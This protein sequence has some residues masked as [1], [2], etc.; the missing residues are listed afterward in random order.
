MPRRVVLIPCTEDRENQL[1]VLLPALKAREPPTTEFY[2]CQPSTLY[3][4]DRGMTI[5][6]AFT[7]SKA[8]GDDVVVVHDVDTVPIEAFPDGYPSPVGNR[9]I[10]HLYGHPHSC[11][12]II[13]MTAA[14]FE[15]M[16]GFDSNPAWG[17]EDTAMQNRAP[18]LGVVV[19]KTHCVPRFHANMFNELDADANPVPN[20]LAHRVWEKEM[21]GPRSRLRQRGKF[22]PDL[23]SKGALARRRGIQVFA[24]TMLEDRVQCVHCAIEK[25]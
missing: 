13:T 24:T 7:A 22:I 21:F 11:G 12:G 3:P 1:R 8:H 14:C 4:F 6:V 18:N 17:G 16:G 20:D 23:Y 2:V 25:L 10:L 5:N 9:E 19:N 15:R